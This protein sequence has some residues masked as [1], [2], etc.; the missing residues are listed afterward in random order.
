[1]RATI[2]ALALLASN[3]V[4]AA[5]V[6]PSG[7]ELAEMRYACFGDDA[8]GFSGGNEGVKESCKQWTELLVSAKSQGSCLA[9]DELNFV[10]CIS[11]LEVTWV[12]ETCGSAL[13]SSGNKYTYSRGAAAD[14]TCVIDYWPVDNPVGRLA[15][16]DG[17][18]PDA[19]IQ[20]DGSFLFGQ[21]TLLPKGSKKIL[22]D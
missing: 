6:L 10:P 4:Y 13:I 3:H 16:S 5:D 2:L 18:H 22:C 15:C 8:E 11:D 12:E 7:G 20:N 21:T 17:S 19:R 9:K 14:V 1:M